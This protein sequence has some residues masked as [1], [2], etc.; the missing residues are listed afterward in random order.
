MFNVT[1]GALLS[2]S[3]LSQ[4]KTRQVFEKSNSIYMLLGNQEQLLQRSEPLTGGKFSEIKNSLSSFCI[5]RRQSETQ[6]TTPILRRK[7]DVK[8]R[9]FTQKVL[10]QNGTCWLV[11]IA[12]S[13]LE[14]VS[15]LLHIHK[16][17]FFFYSCCLAK[18][19]HT[20]QPL[21]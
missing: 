10:K 4:D 9:S 8:H 3:S 13:F 19:T 16:T 15:C 5:D 1:V 20:I 12:R 2:S 18:F 11:P 14:K 17:G 7:R 21:L 6:L